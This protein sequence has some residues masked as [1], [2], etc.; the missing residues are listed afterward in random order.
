MNHKAIGVMCKF[1]FSTNLC[2]FCP[3]SEPQFS[4][5]LLHEVYEV[6][7]IYRTLLKMGLQ[8]GSELFQ[9]PT[10]PLKCILAL[11]VSISRH[12]LPPLEQYCRL[13]ECHLSPGAVSLP[14]AIL[15]F[16]KLLLGYEK[17]SKTSYLCGQ[18]HQLFL[19][20]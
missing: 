18:S 10:N 3:Q 12:I 11:L 5:C 15:H 16:L 2:F 17:H 1:I 8:S 19:L 14:L 20:V 4:G 13:T 9:P 6:C 7:W